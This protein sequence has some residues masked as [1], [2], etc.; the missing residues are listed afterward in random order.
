MKNE[1]TS[2]TRQTQKTEKIMGFSGRSLKYVIEVKDL[3]L[4]LALLYH[5][6]LVI[7]MRIRLDDELMVNLQSETVVA[8]TYDIRRPRLYLSNLHRDVT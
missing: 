3:N 7:N 4:I 8:P 6:A 5:A 1:P 2:S